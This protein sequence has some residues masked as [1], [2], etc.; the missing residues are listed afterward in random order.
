MELRFDA[1]AED[2]PGVKWQ[3]HFQGAWENYERWFLQEGEGTRPYYLTSVRA[4][5]SH[6]P[7]LLPIYEQLVE[8][9]GGGDL[10]A[11]FLSL[12]CPPPYLT[13]CSQAAWPGSPPLLVRNYDYSPRLCE[14]VTLKS[15]WGGKRVIAMSDCLWGVLDGM[16]EDGLAVSLSFGGRK[17]VGEGFGVPI[18]LRYALEFCATVDEAVKVLARVPSH[19]AYN[20]TALDRAGRFAT[21]YVAPDRPAQVLDRP[22]CTNH[23]GETDWERYVRATASIERERFIAARLHDPDGDAQSLVRAFLLPPLY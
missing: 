4:L 17:V 21:V 9:A 18:V 8:L 19:M 10:Q 22:Y 16:N 15:A 3:R 2:V 6:M 20:V 13:G 12:Y 14:G 11:R 7:E 23:Q 5:R 1:I